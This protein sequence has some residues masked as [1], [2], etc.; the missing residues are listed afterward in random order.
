MRKKESSIE[1][2]PC[3]LKNIS[4]LSCL[5]HS[6]DAEMQRQLA[7]LEN[8][9]E[10]IPPE[11]L[12]LD[13]HTGLLS[14][15]RQKESATAYRFVPEYDIPPISIAS[16]QI[17]DDCRL[18]EHP[19]SLINRVALQ[20]SLAPSEVVKLVQEPFA[21]EYFEASMKIA[22]ENMKEPCSNTKKDGIAKTAFSLLTDRIYG[23]LH[24]KNLP[25][26]RCPL[27]CE[28][29]ALVL[30]SL[31]THQISSKRRTCTRQSYRTHKISQFLCEKWLHYQM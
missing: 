29:F 23:H 17:V 9:H 10:D 18:F 11:T 20:H 16:L 22:Q 12:S 3:E 4:S 13:K 30:V 2:R 6:I 8:G 28:S 25:L 26:D 15:Q 1:R 19:D 27:T 31:F 7:M 21:V 14:S 5:Q 24:R